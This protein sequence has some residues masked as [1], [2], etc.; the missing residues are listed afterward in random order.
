[1]RAAATACLACLALA[2][3]GCGLTGGEESTADPNDKRAVALECITEEKGLDAELS[4]NDRI[5]VGDPATGPRIRFYL[6][7]GEAEAEQ[8][9]G[10][11]EGAEQIKN[12]LLF[13]RQGSEDDLQRPASS[14]ASTRSFRGFASSSTSTMP[15]TM[16]PTTTEV[17]RLTRRPSIL[18]T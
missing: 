7:S 11:G 3:A 14:T 12:A 16:I 17:T 18:T 4:G 2:V 5:Q 9:E 6:S 10:R 1:V 8:F 13:V 15:T